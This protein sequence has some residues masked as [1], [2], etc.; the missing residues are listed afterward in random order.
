MRHRLR[1]HK[2]KQPLRRRRQRN[3]HRPESRRRDLTHNNPTTRPPP[4][5]EEPRKQ[6][7]ASESEVSDG[8]DGLVWLRGVEAHVEADDE[9]GAALGDGGPEEG[10]AA[11]E[12]V[13][14][15]EEEG[16]AGYHFYDAVDAGCEEAG[17][18]ALLRWLEGLSFHG[19]SIAYGN[20]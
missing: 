10:F 14:G 12:R 15:E 3:I 20:T 4:K 6:E 9:H 18:G 8:R 1:N 13:G 5:L 19:K 11:A 7:Y 2:I 17:V 16:G